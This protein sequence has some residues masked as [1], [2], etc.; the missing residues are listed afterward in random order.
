[1]VVATVVALTSLFGMLV[2]PDL[3]WVWAAGA[4]LFLCVLFA[5]ALTLPLDVAERPVDAGAVAGMVL[6][7][8]YTLAAIAPT[9]LGFVRDVTGS[10][11]ASLWVL[12]AVMVALLAV[13][14]ALSPRRLATGVRTAPGGGRDSP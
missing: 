9:R 10:F 5:I 13:G 2:I 12:F 11:S 1:M 14:V 6:G 8:G 3:T 7:A 4:G